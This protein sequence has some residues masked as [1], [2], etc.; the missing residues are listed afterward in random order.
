MKLKVMDVVKD[1]KALD[2]GQLSGYKSGLA[3]EQY[4]NFYKFA[5][6]MQ[7]S[8]ILSMTEFLRGN[9]NGTVEDYLKM[10]APRAT[11]GTLYGLFSTSQ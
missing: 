4:R 6:S 8:G 9:V 7:K 2:A 1:M 10:A 11:R 5:E 3:P